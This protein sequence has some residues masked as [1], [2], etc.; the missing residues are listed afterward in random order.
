M[1]I[2]GWIIFGLIVGAIA[3]LLMP[4]PQPMGCLMTM[5]LG[6]AG[7]LPPR[8]NFDR[9]IEM[10]SDIQITR[11]K[12]IVIAVL[13]VCFVVAVM[14]ITAKKIRL[15]TTPEGTLRSPTTTSDKPPQN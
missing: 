13:V 6:I 4:G 1:A 10:K 8:P 11:S 7:S 9:Q 5:L 3:R 15:I 12:I 2:I 14:A